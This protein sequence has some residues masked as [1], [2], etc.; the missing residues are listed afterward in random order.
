[1]GAN[2]NGQ[3][4]A[5]GRGPGWFLQVA[6]RCAGGH[7]S[8]RR[9]SSDRHPDP[10]ARATKEIPQMTDPLPIEPLS[11]PADAE[12]RVPGS[13]SITNRALLLAALAVGESVLTGVLFSEDTRY[14]AE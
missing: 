4:R 7:K 5:S 1:M 12:I 10:S 2:P 6:G 14:M 8:G 13:K 11:K 9:E 3:S